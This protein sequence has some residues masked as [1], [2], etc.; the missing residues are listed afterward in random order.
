MSP[1]DKLNVLVLAA[2]GLGA[3]YVAYRNEKLGA[4]LMVGTTVVTVLY[5]LLFG[6]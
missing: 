5:V 2:V 3:V 1:V 4:A 6:N